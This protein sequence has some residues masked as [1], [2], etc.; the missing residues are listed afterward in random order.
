VLEF[1]GGSSTSAA[2]LEQGH[3]GLHQAERV[4]EHGC[5]TSL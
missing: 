3:G 4:T 2:R 5:V 1:P